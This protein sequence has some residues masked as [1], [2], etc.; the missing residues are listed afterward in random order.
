M[1]IIHQFHISFTIHIKRFLLFIVLFASYFSVVSAQ[2]K[3]LTFDSF[4]QQVLDNHPIVRQAILLDDM[5]KMEI[6]TARGGFDPKLDLDFNRK[7]FKKTVY[8]DYQDYG[9]KIPTW[10]GPNLMAGFQQNAGQFINPAEF[11]PPE[12]LWY[13][14][15][16]FNIMQSIVIDERRAVL[17][18]AL[19]MRQINESE[20]VKIINKILLNAAKDYW[21]WYFFYNKYLVRKKS[22]QLAEDRYQG[23]V[24]RVSGGDLAAMDSIEGKV[25]LQER[26]VDLQD[27]LNDFQN[28]SLSVSNYLWTSDQEPLE[29]SNNTLPEEKVDANILGDTSIVAL[30]DFAE[31]NHPEVRKIKFKITQLQIEKKLKFMQMLPAIQFTGKYISTPNR[32]FSNDLTPEYFF[33]NNRIYIGVLQPLFIRKERGKYQMA[34]IKVQQA[35]FEQAMIKREIVNN[36]KSAQNDVLT[37]Q[38]LIDNQRNMINSTRSLLIAEKNKFDVGESTIFLVNTRESKML[39]SEVKLYDLLAKLEKSKAVLLWSAGK[40]K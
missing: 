40:S 16:D 24:Q 31:N 23:I 17:K 39:D 34:K 18:M 19:A 1:A 30:L 25:T 21:E 14:G 6:R 8:Y 22:Y 11:T 3:I 35:D 12:G 4:Y 20:K 2:N 29:L 9:L 13:L 10:F 7:I 38:Q 15:L 26:Y 33:N 36:V 5:A 32:T 37:Y 27:A 28:A